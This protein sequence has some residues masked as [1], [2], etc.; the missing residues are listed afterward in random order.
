M[1]PRPRCLLGALFLLAISTFGVAQDNVRPQ[2]F[3]I[4]ADKLAAFVGQYQ[5]DDDPDI[6][7]S[8]S[9]DGSHLFTESRRT[10]RV[11]LVAQSE[12]TFSPVNNPVPVT[13]KFIRS[14]EGN[15]VGFNR[16]AAD[17]SIT[18]ARKI[19]DQPL[20][21]EKPE[22]TSQDVMIP[23]RDGIKLHAVILRPK[24]YAAPLPFLMERT[25]YGADSNTPDS[26][27]P[28]EPELASSR[29]IF[30][31]E[32]I[33]GR[34]KSEGTFVM[35]RPMADHRDSKLVDESTDTYD[36]VAWLLKNIPNN[37]GRVGVFGV[38][39]R[40]PDTCQRSSAVASRGKRSA[41]AVR[42]VTIQPSRRSETPAQPVAP[43]R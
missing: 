25:P 7:R 19:S 14:A 8:F 20:H 32:D 26:I 42:V 40:K 2:Q 15:I 34:Y 29:Y 37:N 9:L 5:Y 30:I 23:V 22:Y 18:H 1:T 16:V 12:D 39:S 28:Q 27:N 36:T 13:F 38:S 41:P 21:F 43:V 31:F 10:L 11:E 35:S 17:G 6:I 33:R 3:Q 4:S 24:D